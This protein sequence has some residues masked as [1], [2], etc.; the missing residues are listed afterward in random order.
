MKLI[1]SGL[2]SIHTND[3]GINIPCD[4][5]NS[6]IKVSSIYAIEEMISDCPIQ[7]LSYFCYSC[8]RHHPFFEDKFKPIFK[9][10]SEL[11]TA[12]DLIMLAE[13]VHEPTEYGGGL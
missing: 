11:D 6:R 12:R 4:F 1:R 10:L 3:E 7:E 8:A 9:K 5:C 13:L 2:F